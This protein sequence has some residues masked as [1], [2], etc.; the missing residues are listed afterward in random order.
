MA[1]VPDV[2][3]SRGA[4]GD[5]LSLAAEDVAVFRTAY[6][7]V[8][9][10]SV[11][12]LDARSLAAA[13]LAL[14]PSSLAETLPDDFG[15]DVDRDAG[16]LAVRLQ[17]SSVFDAIDAMVRAGGVP[18]LMLVTPALGPGIGA[19]GRGLPSLAPGFG[20]HA[21]P[22]CGFVVGDVTG[23][24]AADRAGLRV[25]DVVSAIDGAPVRRP[26]A[27]LLRLLGRQEGA[28]VALDIV[29][30]GTPSQ[31]VLHLA[32]L[33]LPLV[34]ARVKDGIGVLRI[35]SVTKSDQPDRDTA[36]LVRNAV[37]ELVAQDV[38]GL[39][40]DLRSNPGGSGHPDVASVLVDGASMLVI[41][42]PSGPEKELPRVGERAP[43][44]APLVVLVD[45]QTCSAGE[46]ISICLREHGNATLVGRATS[47]GMTIPRPIP[48]R[49]GF[50]LMIP[51]A[52]AMGPVTRTPL[53]AHRLDVDI[54]V[55]N[56]TPDDLR[57]GRDAQL[58]EALR[59]VRTLPA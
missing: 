15:S 10:E 45:D 55:P 20:M 19:S 33:Q 50:V 2:S 30:D 38:S 35:R 58:D 17:S 44:P 34:D 51:G 53:P 40:V 11:V 18:H 46:M 52:L 57:A 8:V 14:E 41:R 59:L 37:A 23:G 22:D 43:R 25:G 32:K 24:G 21:V 39:V 6:R 29:R 12:S 42:P 16:W 5:V 7:A 4:A 26:L 31:V 1:R 49:D 36:S 48:L 3:R 13:V 47:G 56:R 27:D 28:A 54:E 9:A